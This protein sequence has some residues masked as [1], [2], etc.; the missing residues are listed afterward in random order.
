MAKE[1]DPRKIWLDRIAREE[2][3]HKKFREAAKDAEGAY[4]DDRQDKRKTL[5]PLFWSTVQIEHS[6]IYANTPKPD[7]RRRWADQP[8]PQKVMAQCIERAMDYMIDSEEFVAPSH[9]AVND[10]LV[11]GLG[12]CRIV[13]SAGTTD[14]PVTNEETGEQVL[15]DETGEPMTSQVLAYQSLHLEY[16]PWNRFRWEPAKDWE[17]VEWVAFDHLL[18]REEINEQFGITI[19]GDGTSEGSPDLPKGAKKYEQLYVVYEIWDRE[20]RRVLY[21]CE[22]H[23]DFLR[24]DDDPLRLKGFYPCPQPLFDNIASGE[25]EPH[26]DYKFV[27]AQ[28]D[29]VNKLTKRIIALTDQIKDVGFYDAQLGELVKL[30]NAEDG[31]LVPVPNLLDR[32]NKANG[33]AGFDAVVAKQDNSTKVQTVNTLLQLRDQAKNAIFESLGIADIIRGA[34]K[35]TETA[36]AQQIKGQWASVRLTQKQAKVNEWFR[37][38]FRIMAELIAEHFT[39]EQ[40]YMMTSVQLTPDMMEALRSDVLRCYAIDVET[41]STVAKD[42]EAEQQGR[43]QFLESVTQAMN[44]LLPAVAQNIIPADIATQLITFTVRSFK[45]GTQL[46]DALENLPNGQAQLQQ[47]G[48]QVQQSQ[49]QT[50]Q[51]QQQAQQQM[52]Q[53]QAQMGQYEQ[54]LRQAQKQVQDLSA[55]NQQ[56]QSLVDQS[57]QIETASKAQKAAAD[58]RKADADATLKQVQAAK[59]A[60]SPVGIPMQ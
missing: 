31:T 49:Q 6:A 47:L 9:R 30:A 40:L 8:G 7:V 53:L 11:T 24:V 48:Q 51:V 3:A 43:M 22:A 15:D 59:V 57:A 29:Y 33:S 41:D 4:F 32:L 45:Y 17:K 60:A 2:K 35:A 23:K 19:S 39:P 25:Y 21:L 10:F 50:Q 36:T 58:A 55:Q 26:P 34:T 5:F 38:I 28:F 12:Q 13:Y 20:T 44:T 46:E 27:Q 54:A 42:E 37:A 1:K 14:E 56:L 18:S 52:A 16:F